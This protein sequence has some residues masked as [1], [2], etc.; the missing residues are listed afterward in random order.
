LPVS[1]RV[2]WGCIKGAQSPLKLPLIEGR[3]NSKRRLRLDQNS[4]NKKM[5]FMIV[6]NTVLN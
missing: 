2:S 3:K 6:R 4:N 5:E 1:L